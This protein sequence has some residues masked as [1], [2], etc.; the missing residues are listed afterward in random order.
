MEKN[1]SSFLSQINL[2]LN[3]L[4]S[5]KE[6]DV[7]FEN[8]AMLIGAGLEVSLSLG[9]LAKEIRNKHLQKV[10][11]QIKD[12]IQGGS[13]LWEAFSISG[14]F[15]EYVLAL[16]RVGEESG[17]LK[18]KLQ[19]IAEQQK[20]QRILRSRIKSALSYP[21]LIII[22]T[23]IVGIGISWFILPRFVSIFKMMN[24]EL[25]VLTK[26][27]V[28]SGQFFAT[29][30]VIFVPTLALLLMIICYFLFLFPK[31]RFSGQWI[32][33]HL[34][35]SKRLLQEVELSR[36]GYNLGTLIKAGL[37]LTT[38]LSAIV[39]VTS[40]VSY[41]K[42]YKYLREKIEEGWSFAHCFSDYKG[43]EKLVP[44]SI[45]QIIV[46]GEESASLA[47]SLVDIGNIYETKTDITA[48]NLT[49]LLEPILLIIIGLGI[50]GVALAI[51]S[52]IYGLMGNLQ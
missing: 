19:I 33:A 49:T 45:Q 26:G 30:G 12:D 47:N 42:F 16:I 38:A 39:N 21:I 40:I 48:K 9:A 36:F 17:Q 23:F 31:T 1:R 7:I 22:L 46:S 52:P 25:P 15:P 6:K 37:P 3:T 4:F 43:S 29:Y 5:A 50:M 18:E 32:L 27:L 11:L 35:V 28:A 24:R 34:P 2:R 13:H 20:K 14:L 51:I 10:V 41:K 8:L 44:A